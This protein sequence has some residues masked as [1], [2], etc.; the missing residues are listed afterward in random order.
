M[1]EKDRDL[2]PPVSFYFEVQ[3]SLTK[4]PTS[5]SFMEV[6]GLDQELVIEEQ[7]QQGD[8]I[9]YTPKA[10]KHS[11]LVLKRPVTPINEE[12]AKWINECFNFPFTCRI[13]PCSVTISLLDCN[14]DAIAVWSCHNVIPV[15]WSLAALN[16]T[17]SD[18]A[19]ETLTLKH[20]YLGRVK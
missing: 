13:K 18:V 1:G 4:E 10:M 8:T 15:K 16:S 12:V 5:T 2:T 19:V 17:K 7:P 11:N 3:F 9:L 20:G 6:E 14:G